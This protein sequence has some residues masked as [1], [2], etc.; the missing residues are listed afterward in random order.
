M[1]ILWLYFEKSSYH[2]KMYTEELSDE[3][4]WFLE[5]ASEPH[6]R[7]MSFETGQRLMTRDEFVGITILF[8]VKFSIKIYF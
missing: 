7:L 8:F 5:F 6:R 1:H 2:L 4:V 3:I